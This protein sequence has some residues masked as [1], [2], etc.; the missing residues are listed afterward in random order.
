MDMWD[1]RLA[2]LA[3]GSVAKECNRLMR[4]FYLV[5]SMGDPWRTTERGPFAHSPGDPSIAGTAKWSG[6][7]VAGP[8]QPVE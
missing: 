6:L 8:Q 2:L 3:P 7:L 1:V 5:C 4:A